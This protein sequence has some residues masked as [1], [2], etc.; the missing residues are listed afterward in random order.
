MSPIEKQQ[1][2]NE[3]AGWVGAVV[4]GPKGDDRGIAVE[5]GGHVW[6]S[7]AEQVLT[8]NA[9]RRPEH[10]PFIPQV[11]IITDPV[12]GAM[13]EIEV[14][15]LVAVDEGRFVPA[16]LRYVPGVE[17]EGARGVAT[18]QAAATA[19][20]PTTPSTLDV[21]AVERHNEV[22]AMGDT[23]QPHQAP[24]VPRA[25]AKAVAAAQPSAESFEA[26]ERS[27][28]EAQAANEAAA[29]AEAA[30]LAAEPAPV[31][32]EPRPDDPAT[33]T[34]NEETGAFTRP[35]EE[36]AQTVDPAVGE[37]TGAALPPQG[38]A[39]AGTFSSHEEVG[40]PDAPQPPPFTPPTEE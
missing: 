5:P 26:E 27:R 3:S 4:I 15:H 29:Q 10:N 13:S 36:T 31:A 14:T 7:E 20:Y 37:E 8:A 1:F 12:T 18:A 35:P 38:D 39:T 30:R 21:G 32:P 16:D 34:F 40:T 2:K 33:P 17:A 19:E 24:P 6:L 11:T 23:A 25:A 22:D 9:P 28:Q